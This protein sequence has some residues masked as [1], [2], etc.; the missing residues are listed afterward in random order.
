M[1]TN[2]HLPQK[3]KNS[4]ATKTANKFPVVGIGSSAGGLEA[5]EAFI[6]AMPEDSGIAFILVAHLDPSHVSIL[7]EIIQRKTRMKVSQIV[8]DM[9]IVPNQIF[10]IPPNK[11]LALLNGRMQL[12]E[13]K[14]PR[15]VHLPIDLFFRSLA[16]D[17]GNNAIAI[18][19]SGTGSDGT[20]G[21]REIK[22]E[23]GM[24]MAQ[25]PE[26]AKYDGMP[27]SA[28]ASGLVDYILYPDQMPQQLAGYVRHQ[29]IDENGRNIPIDEKMIQALP[30]IY[31]LLRAATGHD[32]SLYKK[33]TI[34]RRIEKRMH[35]QQIDK[36]DDY[37]RY[38][39]ESELETTVLFKELLIG[40]TSFFR[41]PGS[42]EL[43][44]EKYLPEL[45]RNKPDDYQMRIWVPG[46]SGG[47]EAY[48]IAIIVRECMD[49]LGIHFTVQIFGTDLNEDAINIARA[50]RYPESIAADLTPERLKK[51]F[52]R[53]NGYYHVKKTIREMVVFAPQNIIKDPPFTRLDLISC[54]NLLIYF[55]SQLQE[56]IFPIFH[57]SLKRDGLLLLGT[58]ETISHASDLFIALDKKWKIFRSQ[59]LKKASPLGLQNFEAEP[60]GLVPKEALKI[61]TQGKKADTA[62]LLKAALAVSKMPPWVIV[63]DSSNLIYVHGRIGQ[64][65]E[66]AEGEVGTN[67]MAMAR[68]G[69]K[70][71]LANAIHRT[72]A[73][74]Q[75]IRVYNLQI[76][77]ENGLTTIDLTVRPLSDRITGIRGLM[78]VIFE[79]ASC[80]RGEILRAV[81]PVRVGKNDDVKRL[82]DELRY[83]KENLQ[84]TI[85]EM[86]AA[87]E[88]LKSSNEELQST[89]E[90]LQ[91][92]NE[93]LETSKEELQS[94][95]E[96]TVTVNAELQS[97]ID[98]LVAANDDIK[99]LLD[100][101]EIG[102]IFLDIDLKIRRFTPRV[103]TLFH[104]TSSDVGRPIAHFASTLK[105]VHL[106]EHAEQVL[107]DLARHESEVEDKNDNV[108]R[109]RIRPYRT[110]SNVIAGVVVTFEEISQ[111][112]EIVE[113]LT[114]SQ[115]LWRGLVESAPMGI[116]IMT[117]GLFTYLNPGSIQLFGAIS[118]AELLGKTITDY[119]HKDSDKA[120][121]GMTD[122]L[123]VAGLPVSAIEQK[124]LQVEGSVIELVISASPIIFKKQQSA[125]VFV[126]EK[127]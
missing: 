93:E 40:V 125:L 56:K 126:R 41:D 121:K 82:E 113:A 86:E 29:P 49:T 26:S 32:F 70:A 109:M 112:K 102:S 16:K 6:K 15:G 12:L 104:L 7:P 75:E 47:E 88:E 51:F 123:M 62:T 37:V 18:I 100:A 44:K 103:T 106:V 21:I 127:L 101:T 53:D 58:S 69:L 66:P 117:E 98:E 9:R 63:D 124:W 92:T 90:E 108:Y 59:S 114:E 34:C 1:P 20:L 39:Q 31:V 94:L 91:S 79:E 97:R 52:N 71:G 105:N 42:F 89:N 5:F 99:N 76:D 27:Q 85:E 38:L 25:D 115:T 8:D 61:A 60:V 10:I 87:N 50:G 120:F 81:S 4:F 65:L 122:Q 57:Y 2:K 74:R 13:V 116:F 119:V 80:T 78:M 107:R 110:L 19:L 36:I 72:A 43:L 54:R 11:D 68:P 77:E 48:T 33:N 17:Q 95:N 14:E 46:C 83:T 30:K 64:F 24:V 28:I 35:V 73:E 55:D 3:R 67:I 84:V 22:G 111:Y 45:L 118:S 23:A 96:E